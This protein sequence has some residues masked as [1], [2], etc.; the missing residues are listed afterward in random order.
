MSMCMYLC[1]YLYMYTHTQTHRDRSVLRS[2]NFCIAKGLVITIGYHFQAPISTCD[3][4]LLGDYFYVPWRGQDLRR[5]SLGA[6]KNQRGSIGEALFGD[7][8]FGVLK[9]LQQTPFEPVTTTSLADVS[10]NHRCPEA[11]TCW[12]NHNNVTTT[13]L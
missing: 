3:G 8:R 4:E 1:L 6:Y 9:H 11:T 13:W 12:A 10:S 5:L 7:V 2:D